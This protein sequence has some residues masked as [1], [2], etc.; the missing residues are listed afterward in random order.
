MDQ[1]DDSDA[2]LDDDEF[3]I[4]GIMDR[5]YDVAQGQYMYQVKWANHPRPTYVADGDIDAPGL[6]RD[7][8]TRHPRG[9]DTSD[10][11]ADKTKYERERRQREEEQR[12]DSEAAA[13]SERDRRR[14]LRQERLAARRS[15]VDYISSINLIYDH[16]HYTDPNL[17]EIKIKDSTYVHY[18][19]STLLNHRPDVQNNRPRPPGGRGKNDVAFRAHRNSA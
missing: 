16:L 18:V 17:Y 12:R 9:C 7:Y 13:K 6:I 19:E 15:E 11:R 8:D 14:Q 10:S 5:R 2:D 3:V 4:A 1:A